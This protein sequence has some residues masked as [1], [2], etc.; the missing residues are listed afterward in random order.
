MAKDPFRQLQ[1]LRN[2]SLQGKKV[3]DCYR[4]MYKKELW[5]YAY[6]RV[7]QRK[8][9]A[10]SDLKLIDEAIAKL[11][12]ET[13]RFPQGNF[14][15]D[16]CLEVM[17]LI[18]K[19]VFYSPN[20]FEQPGQALLYVKKQWQDVVWC[21]ACNESVKDFYSSIRHSLLLSIIAEKIADRRFLLL[22]H[23]AF[24]NMKNHWSHAAFSLM[25]ADIYLHKFDLYM[26]TLMKK[27]PVKYVRFQSAWLIGVRSSKKEAKRL[28]K[29][30][31]HFLAMELNVPLQ[32]P[33]NFAHVE[34]G[35]SFLRYDVVQTKENGILLCIPK[36]EIYLFAHKKGYGTIRPFYAQRRPYLINL[37]EKEI[38]AVYWREL[39]WFM[40]H[41]RLADN[42]SHLRKLYEL[43]K[44]S[45]FLTV[46]HKRKCHLK[47]V[48]SNPAYS[49]FA[50]EDLKWEALKKHP[51][52]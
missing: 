37:Q 32:R 7:C 5:L 45:Y 14:L 8:E 1:V 44:K 22:L 31:E 12:N 9:T 40:R 42:F 15:D 35:I 33:V 4:L 28:Q 24:V 50:W 39:C 3:Y 27:A 46:A 2:A 47:K 36:K 13:F 30:A 21:M 52:K 48:K 10:A 29:D 38:L 20:V 41:Y 51:S 25:M 34:R 11:R 26:E 23:N 17:A 18:L 6:K 49:F 43:A 16:V 19:N